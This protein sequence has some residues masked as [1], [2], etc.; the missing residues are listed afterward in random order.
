MKIMTQI[1]QD[2][3]ASLVVQSPETGVT[4]AKLIV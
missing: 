1:H 4:G 3:I 2:S